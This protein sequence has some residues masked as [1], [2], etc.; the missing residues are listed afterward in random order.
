MLPKVELIQE[1]VKNGIV[2]VIRRIPD[3]AVER[4]A[5]S[6]L[7]G[8]VT[9]LEVTLDSP[10]AF[11]W[12]SKLSERFKGRALIGAGTVLDAESARMA[13]SSGA[14]FLLSPTLQPEV[15]RTGLRYGKIVI[16]GVMTPTEILSAAELGADL[17]KIFPASSLGVQFIKDIKN[18]FP[19][20]SVIPTGGVNLDNAADFIQAGASALGVGGNL[21]DKKAIENSDFGKIRDTAYA[22]VEAVKKARLKS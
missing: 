4:V 6:L 2:A 15:I 17:V 16:P 18:V 10:S 3:E 14:D 8:G 7:D 21:V 1:L 20:I 13:I 11:L 5:D 12:I 9:A 19:Y 22:Y